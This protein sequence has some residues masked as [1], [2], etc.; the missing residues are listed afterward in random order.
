MKRIILTIATILPLVAMAQKTAEQYFN[1]VPTL[2]N[3]Q[4]IDYHSC[5]QNCDD[6]YAT[7]DDFKG[8]I[9]A[10]RHELEQQQQAYSIEQSKKIDM[11]E[12]NKVAA[13]SNAQRAAYAQQ[14][15]NQQ[16]V[17]AGMNCADMTKLL[18]KEVLE[19]KREMTAAEQKAMQEAMMKSAAAR[20][21]ISMSDITAM[22]NMSEAEQEAYI[23]KKGLVDKAMTQRTT[24]MDYADVQSQVANSEKKVEIIEKHEKALAK[25]T[26]ALNKIYAKKGTESVKTDAIWASKYKA[27]YNKISADVKKYWELSGENPYTQEEIKAGNLYKA[28]LIQKYELLRTYYTEA[29]PVWIAEMNATLSS[30]KSELLP[31]LREYIAARADLYEISGNKTDSFDS[32]TFS[33]VDLYLNVAET[34]IVDFLNTEN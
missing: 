32:E 10:L 6:I 18:P 33:C 28:A 30:I 23:K 7:I 16:M 13:M 26:A 5:Q 20:S 12:A 14:R 22:Q 21:G 25:Y 2:T 29:V 3:A 1:S 24:T 34:S 8:K 15:A 17:N 19:G 4:I 9:K 31:A 11:S 27:N